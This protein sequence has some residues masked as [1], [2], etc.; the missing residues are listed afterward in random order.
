MPTKKQVEAL[1]KTEITDELFEEGLER[2]I[3]HQERNFESSKDTRVMTDWYLL[4]LV[5]EEIQQIWLS[6]YFN[7]RSMQKEHQSKAPALS[8]DSHIVAES[9]I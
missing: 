6:N 5:Y 4:Q 2:A 9:V 7:L 3:R 8:R 1:L